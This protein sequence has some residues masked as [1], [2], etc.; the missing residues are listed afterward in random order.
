MN[1][2]RNSALTNS[3]ELKTCRGTLL[4]KYLIVLIKSYNSILIT[5]I[6]FSNQLIKLEPISWEPISVTPRGLRKTNVYY[7]EMAVNTCSN[8]LF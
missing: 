7:A 1:K 6:C 3:K 5:I 2:I 4:F 8:H